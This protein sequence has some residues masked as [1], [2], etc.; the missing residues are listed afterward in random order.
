MAHENADYLILGGGIA[1]TTA[2]ETIR[3]QDPRGR[4]I[5]LD[6]EKHPLYSRVLL[7]AYVQGKIRREQVFLRTI[8]DYE[9]RRIDLYTGEEATVVDMLRKEVKTARGNLWFFKYLLIA[10]GGEPKPWKARGSEYVSVLRLQT[11]DDADRLKERSAAAVPREAAVIGGGFIG[12]ELINALVPQG[13]QVHCFVKE[14]GYWW[15]F[16]GQD[17]SKILERFLE[18]KGVSVYLET[19]VASLSPGE[20]SGTIVHT[21]R[22]TEIQAG[23]VAVGIGLGRNLELLSGQGMEV[24]EGVRTNEVLETAVA[25]GWAAGDIA[26]FYDVTLARSLV[27]GNWS[28][29]FLQ[30]RTAGLN[31]A[32]RARGGAPEAFRAVTT[33]ALTVLGGMHVTFLGYTPHAGEEEG[34]RALTRVGAGERFER[35]FIESGHI[36]GAILLNAFEHRGALERAIRERRDI[37]PLRSVLEDAERPLSDI[38]A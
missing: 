38:L 15:H 36:V 14:P 20:G 11:I 10:S 31:M 34:V 30:G 5:I 8:G 23:F 35:L 28:N 32:R 4:I 25:D 7:P 22:G 27:V 18:K 33:Y 16:L 17:G 1:G 13:I 3:A 24:G 12:L 26:E 19:E 37:T 29:S 9:K 6:K 21:G 2:A